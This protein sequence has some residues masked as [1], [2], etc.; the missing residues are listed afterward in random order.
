MPDAHKFREMCYPRSLRP[1]I[2][3]VLAN[4]SNYVERYCHGEMVA[5]EL[6]RLD[7]EVNKNSSLALASTVPPRNLIR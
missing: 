2:L 6:G 3:E 4:L 7:Y 1:S 5:R